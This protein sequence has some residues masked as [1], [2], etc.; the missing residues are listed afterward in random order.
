MGWG[1]ERGEGARER[2]GGTYPFAFA[3]VF[4]P[5]L[6]PPFA[7]VKQAKL[8]NR[9]YSYIVTTGFLLSFEHFQFN[10]YTSCCLNMLQEIIPIMD[11]NRNYNLVPSRSIARFLLTVVLTSVKLDDFRHF[12]RFSP[13]CLNSAVSVFVYSS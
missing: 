5:P 1:R 6:P 3:S 9:K 12:M 10:H 13:G 7:P 4:L 11:F 2:G 8:R